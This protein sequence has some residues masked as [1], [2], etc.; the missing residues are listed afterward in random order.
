MS[1]ESCVCPVCN[2]TKLVE[3]TEQEKTYSWNKGKTHHACRNCGG[4]TMSGV[5][6]GESKLR[7]DGTPCVHE[8]VGE[9]RGRCY[10]VYYCKHCG[11]QYSIDSGD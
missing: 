7:D 5:A 10:V 9:Q 2:G 4:Q 6:S 1:R 8:Y 11:Y 3:L